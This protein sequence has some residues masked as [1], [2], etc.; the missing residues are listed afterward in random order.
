[1]KETEQLFSQT[2]ALW[3]ESVKKHCLHSSLPFNR[4]LTVISSL[5]FFNFT[6]TSSIGVK[7]SS[8]LLDP[9]YKY[10]YCWLCFTSVS[11]K[12]SSS[13]G[14]P[15]SLHLL[16]WSILVTYIPFISQLSTIL[17]CNIL[18]WAFWWVLFKS[19]QFGTLKYQT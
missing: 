6:W 18:L 3:C 8:L 10:Q 4:T 1:M 17:S 9:K 14:C 5:T 16:S 19:N 12:L 13:I 7:I 15:Q 2:P 11:R